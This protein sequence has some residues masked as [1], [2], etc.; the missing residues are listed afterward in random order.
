MHTFDLILKS[1]DCSCKTAVLTV[2]QQYLWTNGVHGVKCMLSIEAAVEVHMTKQ[3]T[4]V[5]NNVFQ[6]QSYK[7]Q[8]SPI[9]VSY[10]W[11]CVCYILYR[12]IYAI[13]VS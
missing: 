6:N 5:V 1:G 7:N 11:L 10:I 2:I 12:N 8:I 13:Q 4:V 3:S 9:P